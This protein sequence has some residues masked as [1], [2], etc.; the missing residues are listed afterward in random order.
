MRPALRRS[1]PDRPALRR[2]ALR[3]PALLVGAAA[4]LL[5]TGCG[6]SVEGTA[7]PDSSSSSSSSSAEEEPAAD[8]ASGLLPAEAFGPGASVTAVSPEQLAQGGALAGGLA[9]DV[10]IS[11]ESCTG[12]VEGTQPPLDE[13]EDVAG[14]SATTAASVT[15]EVLVRG[16]PTEGAAAQLAEAAANC[17]EAQISSPQIGTA[18]VTFAPLEVGDLGDGAAALQYTTTVTQP[19]GSVVTVPALVGTVEDDDRLVVLVSFAAG[20]A[21]DTA[22]FVDLMA[23][24]YQTQADALG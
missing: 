1:V 9:D 6:D 12:A 23:E 15:V 19:D 22:A 13:F 3:R 20:G 10:R 16:G 17:P 11:P 14:V 2:P 24:A 4:A 21:P 18:T 5:L 7:S 8:L